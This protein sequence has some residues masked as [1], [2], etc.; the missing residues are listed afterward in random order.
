MYYFFKEDLKALDIE[1]ERLQ[2]RLNKI[3]GKITKISRRKEA[4]LETN[5]TYGLLLAMHKILT[6]QVDDLSRV[7]NRSTIEWT[8][9]PKNEGVLIGDTVV[10]Q[11]I[12]DDKEIVLDIRSHWI[13]CNGNNCVAYSA[14]LP[15]LIMGA[16]VGET[17]E[18]FIGGVYKAYKVKKIS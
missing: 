17:R 13:P 1:I 16:K 10:V 7:R 11:N 18:G 12:T 4:G 3:K 15:E 2:V 8:L 9:A 14:P 5:S 6:K